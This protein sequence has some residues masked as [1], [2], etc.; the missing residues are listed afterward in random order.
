[1][2]VLISSFVLTWLYFLLILFSC[3]LCELAR[4][5]VLQSGFEHPFKLHWLGENYM[6]EGPKGNDVQLTNVPNI[7]LT[8]RH[9]ILTT[10]KKLVNEMAGRTKDG[11]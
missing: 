5:S 11:F 4:N 10:E 3:D 7:R 8:Y 9:E 1:M 6:K 2:F